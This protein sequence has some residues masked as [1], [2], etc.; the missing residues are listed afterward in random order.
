MSTKRI[1][2]TMVAGL[3]VPALSL[4]QF[5][6]FAEKLSSFEAMG[7]DPV[8]AVKS[9]LLKDA[10]TI[11]HAAVSRNYPEMTVEQFSDLVDLRN[12][13]EF[14]AAATGTS[15]VSKGEGEASPESA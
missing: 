10:V 1:P 13:S 4:A 5:E 15:V 8:G 6:Q 11:V 2:G 3:L 14:M 9:G 7:T 12:I